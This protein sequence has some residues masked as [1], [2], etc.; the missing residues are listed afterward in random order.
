MDAS[1]LEEEDVSAAAEEVAAAAEASF[2]I[3]VN[4]T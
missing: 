3:F 1:A 4:G 2:Q